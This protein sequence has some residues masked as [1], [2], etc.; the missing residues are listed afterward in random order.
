MNYSAMGPAVG[1]Q[2][3][4][5]RSF[6]PPTVYARRIVVCIRWRPSKAQDEGVEP[7]RQRFGD[8]SAPRLY[9]ARQKQKGGNL[10]FNH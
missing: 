7:P 2:V 3:C 10:E 5:K 1:L 8:A 9:P 4:L 6:L